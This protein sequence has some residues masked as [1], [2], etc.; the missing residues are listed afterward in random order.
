MGKPVIGLTGPTG[1]GKSTVAA[2]F[3]KLGCAVIDADR[4]ARGV[5]EQPACLARLQEAFG[6]DIA[7]GGVLDRRELA[8]R[9]FSSPQATA[10]LDAATHPAVIAE[11]EKR[12]ALAMESGC[13]AVV[14][15][16]A[17]LFESG[18]GR[19]CDA[20]VAVVAP[21]Q[22]RLA[23]IMRRD[24]LAEG[25]A[26]ERMGAQHGAEYYAG[27]AD[28]VL[29][30]GLPQAAVEAAAARLLGRILGGAG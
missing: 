30:G 23:R 21:A 18:A 12:I 13:R 11:A 7:P 20:T 17:L 25:P 19:L 2:V 15:D 26:R 4:I 8:H 10:K 9:A 22:V 24:G 5:V 3:R 28:H 29:D 27:R 1:A 14:V 6:R 16:A